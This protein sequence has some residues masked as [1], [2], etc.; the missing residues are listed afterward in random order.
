MN[1]IWVQEE[2]FM[3]RVSGVNEVIPT[4]FVRHVPDAVA[5]SHWIEG[6]HL[7]IVNGKKDIVK[8]PIHWV[9]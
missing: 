3:R 2:K 8:T 9:D 5:G 1:E 7:H 6:D 4:E